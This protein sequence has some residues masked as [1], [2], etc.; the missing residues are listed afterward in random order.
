MV[1]LLTWSIHSRGAQG[2]VQTSAETQKA[3]LQQR[4]DACWRAAECGD[5]GR[6]PQGRARVDIKLHLTSVFAMRRGEM[7]FGDNIELRMIIAD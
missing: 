2:H 6:R 5:E 1:Y 4:Q 3:G 7:S